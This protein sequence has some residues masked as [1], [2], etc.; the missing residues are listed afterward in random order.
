MSN[1]SQSR[2]MAKSFLEPSDEANQNANDIKWIS[3][4]AHKKA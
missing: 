4:K 2:N 3:D 1:H